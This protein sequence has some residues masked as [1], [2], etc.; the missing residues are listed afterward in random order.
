M[1]TFHYIS[2]SSASVG[3]MAKVGDSVVQMIAVDA[4]TKGS[5]AT[6]YELVSGNELSK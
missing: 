4:D 3:E 5:G 1:R 2:F 6:I